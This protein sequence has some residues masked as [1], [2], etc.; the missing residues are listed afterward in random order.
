MLV[1]VVTHM[2]AF[3]PP[4]KSDASEAQEV[5]H[6]LATP[7]ISMPS[8]EFFHHTHT[9]GLSLHG[10]AALHDSCY[11][12]D[13]TSR[14]SASTA[15]QVAL[16][17]QK[18]TVYLHLGEAEAEAVMDQVSTCTSLISHWRH[19]VSATPAQRHRRSKKSA[20]ADSEDSAAP[21][22]V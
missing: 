8:C 18:E 16:V 6:F 9:H 14:I 4:I 17:L 19:D 10:V 22:Q 1:Q 13:R 11:V 3:L 21:S 20:A 7:S 5:G 15:M 12:P 2:Q